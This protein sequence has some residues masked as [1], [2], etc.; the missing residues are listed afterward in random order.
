MDK[1]PSYEILLVG[2]YHEAFRLWEGN[3]QI[4]NPGC[5]MIQAADMIKYQPKIAYVDLNPAL[6][7][8]EWIDIPTDYTLLTDNHLSIKAERD[9][10]IRAFVET[11]KK[12]GKLSLSFTDNLDKF[13]LENDLDQD[14]KNM[15]EEIKGD[16]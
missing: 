1:Y 10:R 4:I 6:K 2:D 7:V 14:T 12:N 3:R 13:I 15:L 5:M 8:F 11:I 16:N 9:S